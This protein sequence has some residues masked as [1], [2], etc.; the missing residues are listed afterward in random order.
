MAEKI[1]HDAATLLARV[2]V[3][4][5]RVRPQAIRLHPQD[6][7]S[8]VRILRR[9]DIRSGSEAGGTQRRPV[10]SD[11]KAPSVENTRPHRVRRRGT[12]RTIRAVSKDRIR[13]RVRPSPFSSD[14]SAESQGHAL[15]LLGDT[16]VRAL[17]LPDVDG[18]A[19]SARSAEA[20]RSYPK[21]DRAVMRAMLNRYCRA[22]HSFQWLTY[23]CSSE[24]KASQLGI[25][26]F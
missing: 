1:A 18:S 17:A 13:P 10:A 24:R 15:D 8:A 3:Q 19:L 25:P 7:Q 14:G 9:G 22:A 23:H 4:H 21:R 20:P 12:R 11:R 2:L 5:S 26:S 16:V 6:R